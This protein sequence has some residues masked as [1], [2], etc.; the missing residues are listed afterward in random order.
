MEKFLRVSLKGG[1]IMAQ[2]YT[3]G[4]LSTQ[5][6]LATMEMSHNGRR[7]LAPIFEDGKL[8][9]VSVVGYSAPVSYGAPV[10]AEFSLQFVW[11]KQFCR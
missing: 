9:R 3:S 5:V 6:R 7:L 4:D 11:L 2:V 10:G 1:E 8:L